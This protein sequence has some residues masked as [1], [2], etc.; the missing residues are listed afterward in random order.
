MAERL[1]CFATTLRR[2]TMT[3]W[4]RHAIVAAIA[5]PPLHVIASSAKQSRGNEER[6][7]CF[8]ARAPRNDGLCRPHPEELAKRGVSKDG[9][10][11][12]PRGHPSRRRAKSAAP[13]DEARCRVTNS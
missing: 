3:M 6:L 5:D 4:R 9:R 12:W 2:R 13:Q 7:D 10:T 8:V 11:A 1:D